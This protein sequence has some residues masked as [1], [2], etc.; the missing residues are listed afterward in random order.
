MEQ[1]IKNEAV[2][3]A[4]TQ[5]KEEISKETLTEAIVDAQTTLNNRKILVTQNTT[6]IQLPSNGLIN[7][8]INQVT[9]RRMTVKEIKTLH[10]SKDPNYLSTLILGCIVDPANVTVNDLHPNDIIYLLF[11][12]RYISTPNN[13]I[14]KNRCPECGR[15][16]DSKVDIQ[17]LN[18]DYMEEHENEFTC[19]LPECN[20]KL[21]FRILSEGELQNAEK[22]SNR[23]A[24]QLQLDEEDAEWYNLISK[25]AYQLVSKDDKDFEEFKDKVEFLESLSA[26]DFEFYQTEYSKIIRSFG[27]DLK[28]MTECPK[29]GEDI[30]VQAYI[31][32]DFF[33]LV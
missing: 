1:E 19:T 33:R 24:K 29:C 9:L 16:F 26:Y 28:Y 21:T 3:E 5:T 25:T 17:E 10:T 22:I 4:V 7:P 13:L 27:I 12:L 2:Q 8:K 14:Q 30:E 15:E 18:V 11:V 32:P 6:T 20:S 23:K 31:A